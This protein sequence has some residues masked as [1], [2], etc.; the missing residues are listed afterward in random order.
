MGTQE[1][2]TPYFEKEAKCP[3]CGEK[4]THWYLRDHSY[5]IE[6]KEEDFFI[7]KYVWAKP[8]YNAYNI[9][10]FNLW[11]CP[12][13]LYTD[14]RKMFITN[15]MEAFKGGFSE[16]KKKLLNGVQEDPFVKALLPFLEYPADN[17][18][19][20]ML[21]NLLSVYQQHF[22]P[23]YSRNYEKIG[24][25]YLRISWLFRMAKAQNKQDEIIENDIQEYFDLYNKL[26]SNLMN[27]LHNLEEFNQWIE[28][29]IQDDKRNGSHFWKKHRL[30]FKQNYDWFVGIW[31]TAIPLLQNYDNIGKKR[32]AEYNALHKNPFEAPFRE[33]QTFKEFLEFLKTKWEGVP[34]SE[35]QAID[36]AIN[37]FYEAIK[38]RVFDNKISRYFSVMR[39]IV[40]LNQK[41]QR[42]EEALAK[43]H[44]LLDRLEY[45]EKALAG[46]VEKAKTLNEGQTA[47]EQLNKN[48]MKIREMIRDA[49]EQR[50]YILRL[51]EEADEK[52]A[53]ELFLSHR[54][55]S[56]EELA[57]LMRNN[58]IEESIIKKY[59]QELA[60]EKKKGLFQIF[61]F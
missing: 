56:P 16:T 27:A 12:H 8:E 41:L 43:S 46:R 44:I 40:Y 6:K 58:N 13:C 18:T 5:T 35:A 55:L 36:F 7:S 9:Y 11:H 39:L 21:L 28:T 15:K 50:A 25:L 53:K 38:A 45:Y 37:N 32:E 1:N 20:Q 14:E 59:T 52:R 23:D 54:E 60:T 49:R 4:T 34:T 2:T 57:E 29:K 22:P 33:Y 3:V 26:Q 31:D 30:E 61:K 48:R 10:F 42:Y 47:I 24:K 51:K 19:A 17:Y